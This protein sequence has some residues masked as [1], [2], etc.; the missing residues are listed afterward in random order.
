MNNPKRQLRQAIRL[1]LYM[2]NKSAIFIVY[3]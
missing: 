1:G 3:K 2:R